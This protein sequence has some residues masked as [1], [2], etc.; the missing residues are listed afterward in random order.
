MSAVMWSA[1][2]MLSVLLKQ[3]P[4]VHARFHRINCNT[5]P[6]NVN[7]DSHLHLLGNECSTLDAFLHRTRNLAH[8]GAQ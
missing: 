8:H 2:R 1:R 4:N 6:R 5:T 3:F 7:T